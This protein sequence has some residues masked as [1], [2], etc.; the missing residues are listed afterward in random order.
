M[1]HTSDSEIVSLLLDHCSDVIDINF[2]GDQGRTAVH[3]AVGDPGSLR[4]LIGRCRP[5]LDL[6]DTNG[7]SALLLAIA[8]GQAESALQLIDAGCDFRLVSDFYLKRF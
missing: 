6:V 7:A 1:I 5:D 2:Q 3:W 4:L 8:H